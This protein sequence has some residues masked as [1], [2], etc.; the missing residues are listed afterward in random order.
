[1]YQL[2]ADRKLLQK[3]LE[4]ELLRTKKELKFKAD[5]YISEQIKKK[6]NAGSLL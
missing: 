1:M 4:N 6:H 3:E 2:E 5:E